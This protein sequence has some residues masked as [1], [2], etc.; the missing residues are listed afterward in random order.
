MRPGEPQI[1]EGFW[2]LGTCHSSQPLYVNQTA[3]MQANDASAS[4]S[5]Q[6]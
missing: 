2:V 5:E 3:Q 4:Y 1:L 6:I